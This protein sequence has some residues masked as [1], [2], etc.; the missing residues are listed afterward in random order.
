M[1]DVEIRVLDDPAAE[2]AAL[3]VEAARAG[4]QMALSGG[5]TPGR[6]FELAAAAEP[7]WG[8]A[9][10][11]W[12][13]ERAVPPD[14]G[15]SNFRL[16]REHLLD[17][18]E[19]EPTVHRVRGELGADAAAEAYE[20]ELA[21]VTL[22]LAL[23]GIGPDGHTGS[24][25]PGSPWLDERERLVVAAEPGLEPLVPRI[26]L[27]VAAFNA[28]PV[29]VFLATGETK[30]DAVRRAFAEEPGPETPSSLVRGAERTIALLDGAAAA[31]I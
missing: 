30:A 27:T 25:F 9:E 8:R 31:Y 6:A 7:D 19:R 13:D 28:I 16:A 26:T 1:S 10:V 5:S 21:G 24:L 14:D 23:N 3:L 22:D 4:R 2:A 15:R 17:R 11:W 29:V 20:H 18:L 12:G